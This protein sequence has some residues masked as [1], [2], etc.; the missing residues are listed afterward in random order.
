MSA[1][2]KKKL[3]SF[4]ENWKNTSL[5]CN[6]CLAS[7]PRLF[8]RVNELFAVETIQGRKLF[9]CGNYMSKYGSHYKLELV[10][11]GEI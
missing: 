6:R 2:T 1:F 3:R 11:E 10:D 8:F 7:V 4:D 5:I 9:K